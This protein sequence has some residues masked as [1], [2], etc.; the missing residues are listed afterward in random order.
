MDIIGVTAARGETAAAAA[1]ELV[2]E[3]SRAA[4]YRGIGRGYGRICGRWKREHLFW[5]C[6]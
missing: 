6:H 4:A 2:K 1:A 3:F 5:C